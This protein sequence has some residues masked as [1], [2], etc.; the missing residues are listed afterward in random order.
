M[1]IVQY[2]LFTI[3]IPCT[4][5][6]YIPFIINNLLPFQMNIG[7]LR[8]VGLLFIFIGCILYFSCSLSFLVNKGTPAMWFV[9]PLEPIIGKEPDVLVRINF[10]KFSRNPMYLGVLS[11][12]FGTA[13]FRNSFSIFIYFFLLVVIFNIVIIFLE[14]PHLKQKYGSGYDDYFNSVPRWFKLH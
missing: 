7:I 11:I 3:F 6:I 10:Y 4:I 8:Y 1:R 12:I 5:G 9:R 14:E 13:I 2:L